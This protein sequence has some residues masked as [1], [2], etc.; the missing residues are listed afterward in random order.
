[1]GTARYCSIA[2]HEGLEQF[3]KDDLESLGYILVY[4]ATGT[5]PW[6]TVPG[7]KE[8]DKFKFIKEKKQKCSVD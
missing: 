2:A 6:K 8:E 1:M 7:N 5:L 4:L 3:P